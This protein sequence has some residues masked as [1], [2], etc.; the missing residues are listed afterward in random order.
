MRPLWIIVDDGD[1]FEG[2]QGHWADCFFSNATRAA[3]QGFLDDPGTIH[4]PGEYCKYIIREMTDDELAK[5]PEALE[6][7]QHL[8][9]EYGEV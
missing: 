7:A 5:H 4:G 2:H 6:F 8:I 3:I 1:T 9:E